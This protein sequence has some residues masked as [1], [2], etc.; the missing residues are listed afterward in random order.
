M[1]KGRSNKGRFALC[2]RVRPDAVVVAGFAHKDSGVFLLDG[3]AASVPLR[4]PMLLLSCDLVFVVATPN[5]FPKCSPAHGC[6]WLW[7]F[8]NS[9]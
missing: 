5:S 9:S 7:L 1:S 8:N 4:W 3:A 6:H 2:L